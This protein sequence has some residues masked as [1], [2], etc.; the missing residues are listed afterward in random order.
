METHSFTNA[1]MEYVELDII[2]MTFVTKM[3]HL[4]K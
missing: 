4:I 1:E 2:Y 3:A